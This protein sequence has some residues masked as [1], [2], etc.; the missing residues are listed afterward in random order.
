MMRS[1]HRQR[2]TAADRHALESR[3]EPWVS[4][5]TRRSWAFGGGSHEPRP[6]TPRRSPAARP[7]PPT[8]PDA[9]TEPERAAYV[10]EARAAGKLARAAAIEAGALVPR[11]AFAEDDAA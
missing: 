11:D 4:H 3:P 9:L 1:R 7:A 6:E 8:L 5:D 2:F 10:A